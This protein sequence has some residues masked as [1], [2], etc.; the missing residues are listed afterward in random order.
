MNAADR[1]SYPEEPAGLQPRDEFIDVVPPD[2]A[3]DVERQEW[4]ALALKSLEA[5][6]SP[7]EP[8]YTTDLVK[9]PGEQ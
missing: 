4:F 6:G 1:Q 3:H 7:D 5:A 9:Q 8:E 2:D